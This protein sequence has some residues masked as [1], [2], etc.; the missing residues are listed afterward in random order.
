[1]T[2]RQSLRFRHFEIRRF[3][4]VREDGGG[5]K[6]VRYVLRRKIQLELNS[7]L[8]VSGKGHEI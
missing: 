1:M 6:T 5:R 4:N 8:A 3:L 2:S 7:C